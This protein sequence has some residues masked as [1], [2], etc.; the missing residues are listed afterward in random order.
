MA[1]QKSTSASALFAQ[2]PSPQVSVSEDSQSRYLHL[3]TPWVQGAMSLKDPLA[4]DL[5]Y[6]QRMMGWL[7]FTPPAL[8]AD[9]WAAL[10]QQQAMQLGLGAAALTKYHHQVLA[11]P[12]TAIEI[13]PVVIQICRDW[14]KLPGNRPGLQVVQADAAQAIDAASNPQWQGQIHA[15]QVDLY[16]H[17]AAAPVLDSPSFYADCRALLA[18]AGCMAVNLFGRRNSYA[19]SLE[20]IQNAFGVEQVWAFRPT[21]E[22]N[23]IVLA[24]RQPPQVQAGQTLAQQMRQHADYI[25]TRWQ[26]PARKWLK[27]L[28]PT[29]QA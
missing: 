10:A 5:E 25:Q 19:S 6:V 9:D 11:M 4:L 27:M 23:T 26:L 1:R 2:A 29:A 22:G 24:L 7:L 15:L 28:H 18:P 17:E 13:N 3:G 14:F 16:D 21:R 12:T 8:A 20:K